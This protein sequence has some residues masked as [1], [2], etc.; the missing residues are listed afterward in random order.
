MTV[1]F[2]SF[3]VHAAAT[4]AVVTEGA[5]AGVVGVAAGV[6]AA[7]VTTAV[8]TLAVGAAEAVTEG[9]AEAVALADADAVAEAV[10]LADGVAEAV[11]EGRA[12]KLWK[13]APEAVAVEATVAS[14]LPL[15]MPTMEVTPATSSRMTAS[16]AM[17]ATIRRRRYT[18][19]GRTGPF[20][21]IPLRIPGLT[22]RITVN[23]VHAVLGIYALWRR[24]F[25]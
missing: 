25:G 17:T 21:D 11:S 8:V 18:S 9:V 22:L 5:G 24:L 20:S 14:F 23:P 13:G 4:A 7:G 15:I 2:R 3:A 16:R 19:G 10:A 12:L 1:T 6:V